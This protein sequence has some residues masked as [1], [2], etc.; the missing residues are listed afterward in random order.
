[1]LEFC[2]FSFQQHLQFRILYFFLIFGFH[3]LVSLSFAD[4]SWGYQ[5]LYPWHKIGSIHLSSSLTAG[6]SGLVLLSATVLFLTSGTIIIIFSSFSQYSFFSLFFP[7][8]TCSRLNSIETY[9]FSWNMEFLADSKRS[10]SACY[11]ALLD[12]RLNKKE[13]G[14]GKN[15]QRSSGPVSFTSHSCIALPALGR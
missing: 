15:Q 5:I 7:E 13:H 2:F 11:P 12:I 1:M 3:D 8:F 4:E 9:L 14:E 6:D 10:A